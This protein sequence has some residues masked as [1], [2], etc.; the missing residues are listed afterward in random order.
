M[1]MK[2]YILLI[3]SLFLLAS[4]GEDVSVEDA[5]KEILDNTTVEAP[6]ETSSSEDVSKENEVQENRNSVDFQDVS[7]VQFLEFHDI[8]L[9]TLSSGEVIISGITKGEVDKIEV[10]FSNTASEYPDDTYTLKTFSAG[11]DAFKYI[12]SSRFQ[13]MDYGTNEYLFRAYSG[14]EVSEKKVIITL[15]E[16]AFQKPVEISEDVSFETKV[17][18]TEEDSVSLNLPSSETYGNPMSL[19]QESFT[20]SNIDGFE[21]HKQDVSEMNCENITD[22]LSESLNTWFYWNTCRDIIKEKGI[23]FYVLRLDGEKYVYEKHYIDYVHGFYATYTVDTGTG[24]DKD[25][26]AEKNSEFK[27]RNDGFVLVEVTDS[28]MKSIV[29]EE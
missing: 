12:A 18:G 26:I 21:I 14:K 27:E 11:D 10:L 17:I 16:D 23:S 15:F 24:I 4:C 6:V 22:T 9:D 25:T 1:Y 3:I 8:P 29:S 7:S 20:Y 13:V 2:K 19:S 5:K 28:L